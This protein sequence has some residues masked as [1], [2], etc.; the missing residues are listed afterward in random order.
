MC[1]RRCS[2]ARPNL[3]RAC[4]NDRFYDRIGCRGIEAKILTVD[5][6][7]I[8]PFPCRLWRI[9]FHIR[10]G[11][12]WPSFFKADDSVMLIESP[13]D[14]MLLQKECRCSACGSH[15]GQYVLSI[16]RTFQASPRHRC[17]LLLSSQ[18]LTRRCA[19]FSFFLRNSVFYDGP[20]PTGLRYCINGVA[21]EF[22]PTAVAS[23]TDKEL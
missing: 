23:A 5:L 14:K 2:I 19:S 18:Y 8:F 22:A 15:L 21:L 12:G 16:P 13:M 1:R 10:S 9:V 6:L 20:R 3:T 4:L 17:S 11:T 7:S